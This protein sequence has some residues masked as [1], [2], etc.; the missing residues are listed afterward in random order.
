[1]IGSTFGPEGPT[2]CSGL[3]VVRYDAES[4]HK[5]FGNTFPIVGKFQGSA[6]HTVWDN[7]AVSL[8]LLQNR[9]N[10]RPG[11]VFCVVRS[12]EDSAS[13]RTKRNPEVETGSA[14]PGLST[15]VNG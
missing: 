8:S 10:R 14:Y 15:I 2:K 5:E 1:M 13:G 7:T 6:P 4:L 3:D 9:M 12:V 11:R